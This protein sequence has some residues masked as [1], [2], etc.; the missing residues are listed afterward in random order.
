MKGAKG[1]S[2]TLFS[3]SGYNMLF[4]ALLPDG[5]LPTG[6]GDNQGIFWFLN[7]Q[8]IKHDGSDPGTTCN[9]QFNKD[10]NLGYFL[11][12]NMDASTD[13]HETAYFELA[14][15]VHN[16]ITEFTNNN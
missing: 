13:E 6:F 5:K 1:Q 12:T 14:Q 3:A 8:D 7:G 11:M 9:L 15:M 4:N 10:G 16:A 2:T